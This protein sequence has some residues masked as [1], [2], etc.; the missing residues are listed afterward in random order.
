[1]IVPDSSALELVSS[2]TVFGTPSAKRRLPP[3]DGV[4]HRGPDRREGL[5]GRPAAEVGA[6]GSARVLDDPVDR[7]ELGTI[8]LPMVC[9]FVGFQ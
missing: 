9:S 5:V 4:A 1:M 8:T 7:D 2:S 3:P 6:L